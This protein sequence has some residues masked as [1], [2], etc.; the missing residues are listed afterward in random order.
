MDNDL[1]RDLFSH[2]IQASQT[3]GVDASFRSDI[4]TLQSQLPPDQVGGGGQLQ[5]WL[6]DVD[7]GGYDGGHRHCSHLVGFFP[8]DQISPFY[9]PALADGAKTSIYWRGYGSSSLTPWSIS[10]RLNLRDR[11][12]DGEGAFINLTNLYGYNKVS[13][14]LVFADGHQQLDSIFGRLSGIAEM[15]LQSHSGEVSLLPALP[16]AFTNGS[17]SGLCA[18]GGFE[19]DTLTW[20]NGKLAGATI[21]SKLGNTCNLRS[22]WPIDVKLGT[23]YVPAPMV[24]PGLYQFST[25]AGSNYTILS[26]N[27]AETENLSASI[28]AGDTHQIVTNAAFSNARGTVLNA[29]AANDYVTY[30]VSNLTAGTYHVYIGADA[31]ANRGRF[32]LACGSNGGTLT[33]VGSVQDTYSATNLAYLLPIG[34]STPTNLIVLWTNRLRELDC[35]TWQAPSNGNYSFRFTVVDKNT[36]SSGYNLAFD[37]IKLTPEASLGTVPALAVTG[38]GGTVVLSW[39]VN[40]AGFSLE[41]TTDLSAM[42]WLPV[43]VPPVVMGGLNVVTNPTAGAV[44]FYRLRK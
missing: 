14:N 32:Q 44:K 8:G 40:P 27:V 16:R 20:T 21:L 9:T 4:A 23:N 1:L 37:Y 19:V 11:L 10:W 15:F 24:L 26:A 17:V 6:E 2:V 3:L 25:I 18:R 42:N 22:K 38:Q 13:T 7:A 35:G 39:P 5:E 36:S 31:G 28:S 33:N 43:V 34:L 29:N 41:Y 30:V 12:Q